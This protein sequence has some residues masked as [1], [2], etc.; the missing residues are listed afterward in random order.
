MTKPARDRLTRDTSVAVADILLNLSPCL[1]R[2]NDS[3]CDLAQ[4]LARQHHACVI[5]VVDD[6]KRLRGIIRHQALIDN[7]FSRIMPEHFLG[8]LDNIK[9]ASQFARAAAVVSAKDIMEA[10]V[11]I[12]RRAEV[13][14]A[15]IKMHKRG[16][17]GL[18]IVDDDL[19]VVGY[20][21]ALELI[22]VWALIQQ[23]GA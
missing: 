3:V 2:E 12:K 9:E 19:K 5:A 14:E 10:P 13:R 1:A 4:K 21:D 8:D 6:E 18:P 17:T 23:T 11:Y 7:I 22:T 16:V 15:I 20:L